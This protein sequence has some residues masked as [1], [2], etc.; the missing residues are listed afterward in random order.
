MGEQN[1]RV[2][3][4]AVG[5]ASKLLKVCAREHRSQQQQQEAQISTSKQQHPD[6]ELGEAS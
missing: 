4:R 5:L 3:G 6:D 2:R 1:G